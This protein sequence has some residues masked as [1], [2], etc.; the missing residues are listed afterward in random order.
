MDSAG[1]YT[2]LSEILTRPIKWNLIRQQYDEMIKYVTAL[3][4]G[5]AEAEA[6]LCRF[7]RSNLLQHPTYQALAE[8]GKVLKTIFLCR[9][10]S[11]ESLRREIHEGLNV[12]ENWNSANGFIFYGKSGEVASNR[13]EDQELSVLSLHLLQLCMVYVNTLM[14]QRVLS[15][16]SW[17]NRMTTANL[18]ALSPLIYSHVNPYGRFDL[19][20]NKRLPIE[21]DL[22]LV[23]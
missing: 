20:M 13:L 12:V 10:I 5:T 17:K 14:I 2:N 6:I 19:D 1:N 11:S 23:A 21:A 15:E 16:E 9:Y 18:R 3:R 22:L 4:L 7:T 8:L